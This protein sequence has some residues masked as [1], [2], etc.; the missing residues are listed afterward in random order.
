MTVSVHNLP[1]LVNAG[2]Y[3]FKPEAF[4]LFEYAVSL[5]KDVFP[6]LAKI[7]QL[8]GYFTY[9]EYMHATD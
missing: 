7:K 1:N 4:E 9:G 3:I 8:A 2:I 5:E 6:K